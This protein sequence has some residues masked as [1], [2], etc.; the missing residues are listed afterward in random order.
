[1]LSKSTK[2]KDRNEKL[3]SYVL[4]EDFDDYVLIEQGEMRIEHFIKINE[5][6]WNVRLLTEK[7]DKLVLESI[8]CEISLNE[9]YRE[10]KFSK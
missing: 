8:N 6:G 1:V 2:L 4:I 10:A 7:A 5:K 9:V 3:D